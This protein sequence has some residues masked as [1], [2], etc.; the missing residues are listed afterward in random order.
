MPEGDR[1]TA[2]IHTFDAPP[3]LAA[4]ALSSL[5]G[6]KGAG[7]ARMT[8]LGLPVPP[9]FTL[10][11]HVCNRVLED[12]WF[13]ELDEAIAHGIADLEQRLDRRLGDPDRPLLVSVRSGAPVSMPGMTDT[14][15]N[16]GMTDQVAAALGQRAD[17][18]DFGA[19]T[20]RRFRESYA[21]VVSDEIPD[22]PVAQIREAVK[23]VFASW[24]SDRARVYRRV[25][26]ID[27][28]LGTAATIQAMV[29]GNL[30]DDSGTGVAFTRDPATGAPG[31][32][33]DFL[34]KAQ[35]EDVV[36]GT[37]QTQPISE[38]EATW[39]EIAHQL[40]DISATLEHE[41]SD[42]VDIEFTVEDRTLWM[43]QARVG[44]RS[45]RAA[46]RV[47]V[48]MANDPGFPTDRVEAV[49][50]VFHLLDD[51]PTESA[52]GVHSDAEVLTTGLAASPGRVS[53]IVCIDVDDAVTLA[54][55]G[56]SVVLC[57]PET[58][59]ADVHGMA[60]AVGI[61]TT[62]GGLV[63]H[64]A[65]V[66]RSWGKPAVV[67][68]GDLVLSDDGVSCGGV[69]IALGEVVTVDGDNGEVLVGDH[70][71]GGAELP[72]VAVLRSWRDEVE[73]THAA[74]APPHRSKA[75]LP[76]SPRSR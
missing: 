12:G 71:T 76:G 59:P 10:P 37:H 44:K 61:V 39:P 45:P 6:G 49:R 56:E 75:P 50:R 68:A 13:P 58:S 8:G 23:A 24:N 62:L 70:A 54:S 33:G 31:L 22:D 9:G 35:G 47:A 18:P 29:F 51:P 26:S 5:L 69:Q 15:L 2:L 21:A 46:L 73:L 57:R 27:D 4:D 3:D 1:T 66:A 41:L 16:A 14:V 28:D 32:K 48:A 11:T 53:G 34:R 60:E 36:A 52:V 30:S 19:D 40:R 63:S 67:G 38:L 20:H 25:E 7:L 55:R 74:P 64:A 65:V 17:D 42:M 43:L 72:E